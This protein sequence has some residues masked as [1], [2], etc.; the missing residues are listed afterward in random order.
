MSV[1]T[2]HRAEHVALSRGC[3]G[4]PYLLAFVSLAP[5][6]SWLPNLSLW[7]NG[8]DPSDGPVAACTFSAPRN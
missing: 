5:F 2:V 4:A 6:L 7:E 3:A 8:K 1:G